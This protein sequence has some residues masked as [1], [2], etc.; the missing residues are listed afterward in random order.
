MVRSK[1]LVPSVFL[2]INPRFTPYQLKTKLFTTRNLFC[3]IFTDFYLHGYIPLFYE[4]KFEWG[5][6]VY[7]LLTCS[8]KPC[9]WTDGHFKYKCLLNRSFRTGC[10]NNW[11]QK[12]KLRESRICQFVCISNSSFK[13]NSTFSC[14]ILNYLWTIEF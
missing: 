10:L 13:F 4:N 3:T 14:V 11:S 2:E 7:V 9:T 8:R 12:I 5:I 6:S 1:Q